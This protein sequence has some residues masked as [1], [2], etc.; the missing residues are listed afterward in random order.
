MTDGGQVD[1][2]E[3]AQGPMGVYELATDQL[4][5]VGFDEEECLDALDEHRDH[6]ADRVDGGAHAE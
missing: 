5:K 2:H 1:Q 4:R 6:L 3:L